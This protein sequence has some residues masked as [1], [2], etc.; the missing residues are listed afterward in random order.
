MPF[1]LFLLLLFC[2]GSSVMHAQRAVRGTLFP[3]KPE[4]SDMG[5]K[6]VSGGLLTRKFE[7]TLTV[8]PGQ[9]EEGISI[10]K[11]FDK[12][13]SLFAQQKFPEACSLFEQLAGTIKPDDPLYFES[14]FMLAEC[15]AINGILERADKILK[16][17][18]SSRAC[19]PAILEKSLVRSGHVSCAR[20]IA[21]DAER[22]FQRLRKEFPGSG[23]LSIANCEA[24]AR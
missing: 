2:S 19:P 10:A 16:M 22:S 1:L 13:S 6:K 4:E 23:Y 14:Q 18:I 20:G 9:A 5:K 7:D 12:A 8:N 15:A 11:E 17:L 3:A 24:V 21:A